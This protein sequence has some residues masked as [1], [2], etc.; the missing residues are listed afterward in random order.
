MTHRTHRA[1]AYK[2]RRTLAITFA[3]TLAGSAY[4]L[5]AGPLKGKTYEGGVPSM[6]VDSE[7]H[8]QRTH[9]TGNI[10]LR[11]ASNGR[12]VSVRFSSAI[13]YCNTQEKLYSQATK[14]ASISRSGTFTASI[15]ERFSA[16][17]GLPAIVQV[18]KGRFSGRSVKGTIDTQ[19]PQ[20]GGVASFSA[21]AR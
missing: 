12:S 21:A 18:V 19:V 8:H 4:A 9:A 16:G 7:G 5:A 11:V 20:C 1:F 6:G 14:P 13:L 2:A 17:P 3:L 10:V 15:G